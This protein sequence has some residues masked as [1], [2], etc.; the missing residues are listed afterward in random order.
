MM[1]GKGACTRGREGR[2]EGGREGGGNEGRCER[3]ERESG[4]ADT[5]RKR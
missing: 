2:R 4:L 1:F 5:G 3:E